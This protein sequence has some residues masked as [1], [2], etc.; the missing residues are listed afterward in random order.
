L[1]P[2]HA[3]LRVRAA[4]DPSTPLHRGG[5]LKIV[6]AFVEP[7]AIDSHRGAARVMHAVGDRQLIGDGQ[8]GHVP[9]K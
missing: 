9:M 8:A 4:I 6:A 7:P 2:Q 3:A 1:L 5:A